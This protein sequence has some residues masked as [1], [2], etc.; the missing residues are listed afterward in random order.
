MSHLRFFYECCRLW[1][2]AELT[3]ADYG[4]MLSLRLIRYRKKA[5][6]LFTEY[7]TM[8]G[9]RPAFIRITGNAMAL[10]MTI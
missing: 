1:K 9:A 6:G 10:I 3:P 7:W 2:N 4:K 5:F 8:P